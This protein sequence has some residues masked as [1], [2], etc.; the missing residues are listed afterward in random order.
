MAALW[1]MRGDVGEEMQNPITQP[2]LLSWFFRQEVHKASCLTS[3]CRDLQVY[4]R[5][6]GEAYEGFKEN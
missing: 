4:S 5:K 6:S 3:N 1:D 2:T